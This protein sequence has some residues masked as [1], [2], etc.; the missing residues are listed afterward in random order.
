MIPDLN[1]VKA[2]KEAKREENR[3]KQIAEAEEFKAYHDAEIG[4][5]ITSIYSDVTGHINRALL[6]GEDFSGNFGYTAYV[7]K[8]KKSV[9]LTKEAVGIVL[10]RV[11]REY[12]DAG[13]SVWSFRVE[14]IYS[15]PETDARGHAN[16]C[17]EPYVTSLFISPD[18][19]DGRQRKARRGNT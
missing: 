3:K 1:K 17:Y 5:L 16:H 12:Y 2:I 18:D 6:Q 9:A 15:G 7:K 4:E 8:Y 19:W 13:Y 11:R 14:N 10:K